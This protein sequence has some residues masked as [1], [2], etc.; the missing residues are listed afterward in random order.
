MRW[1]LCTLMMAGVARADLAANGGGDREKSAPV[2]RLDLETAPYAAEPSLVNVTVRAFVLTA[3]DGRTIW[4]RPPP[5]SLAA[6]QSDKR[7]LAAWRRDRRA[8][9]ET[10]G[11]PFVAT[12]LRPDDVVVIAFERLLVFARADGKLRHEE[13]LGEAG[14]G[15]LS[16]AHADV[17][18]ECGARRVTRHVAAGQFLIDCGSRLIYYFNQGIYALDTSSYALAGT[19]MFP[20]V[21]PARPLYRYDLGGATV[22]LVPTD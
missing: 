2:L 1:L 16:F 3:A 10:I 19:V 11:F 13:T 17:T 18:V 9:L 5:E 21:T 15:G 12:A 22:T 14:F 20:D 6:F 7:L 4:R 8:P